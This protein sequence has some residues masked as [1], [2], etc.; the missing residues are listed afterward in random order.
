MNSGVIS[1][2]SPWPPLQEH[3][4]ILPN[5]SC[6]DPGRTGCQKPGDGAESP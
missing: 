6:V 5:V 3:K 4:T 2:N 1:L